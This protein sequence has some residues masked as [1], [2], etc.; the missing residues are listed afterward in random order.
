[1]RTTKRVV[2]LALLTF[3]ALAGMVFSGST[4]AVHSSDAAPATDQSIASA[5]SS[6]AGALPGV[7][8]LKANRESLPQQGTPRAG[9]Q[10]PS[11]TGNDATTSAGDGGARL[12]HAQAVR[13]IFANML[14]AGPVIEVAK[15]DTLVDGDGD[16]KIDPTNGIPATTEKITY[17]VTL[18]NTGDA[19]AT[20]VSF[21]DTIDPHTTLVPGS[22]GVTPVAVNDAYTA[23]G[24]VSISKDAAAGLLTNDFDP[25]TGSGSGFTAT[26]E[27]KK[28]ANCGACATNNVTINADGSFTYDPPPGFTGD[29]TF[30]YT[31]NSPAALSASGT[32]TI[33]ISGMIWFINNNAGA[34]GDATG[35]GRLSNPF[36]LISTFNAQNDGVGTHPKD[37]QNIFIYSSPNNYA[38]PLTLRNDQK[39]I[40][41]GS[42]AS[43]QTLTG[44]T[45][46]AGS[47]TL[48]STGGTP[49][50]ITTAGITLNS[51]N[52]GNLLRGFNISGTAG[53]GLAGSAFG[54]LSLT[55]V[56]VSSNGQALN[57]ANGTLSGPVASTAVFGTVSSGGGTDGI[58]LT[59]IAGTMTA[60]GGT[61]TGTASGPT[62]SVIGG[63]VNVTYNGGITQAANN[64]AVSVSGGHTTGTLLFQTGT[65]SAT[66]G[67]GLQ[68]SNADGVYQFTGTTTLNGGDAGID[69][70]TGSEGNFTFSTLTS[71]TNPTGDAFLVNGGGGTVTYN[72]TISKNSAGRAANIQSRTGGSV[73][74]TGSISSTG[75]SSGILVQNNSGGQVI[76]NNATKTLN[77]GANNA[78]TLTSNNGATINLTNGL[79]I[80]TTS[81][82]GFQATGG[83]IVNVNTGTNT[84]TSTSGQ[85]IDIDGVQIG[86][87]FN[88]VDST[89]STAQGIDLTNLVANSS[90]SVTGTTNVTNAGSSLG[91]VTT[92]SAGAASINLNTV[93]ASSTISFGATNINTRARTGIQMTSVQG[94]VGFGA[95]SI[96]LASGNTVPG[97]GIRVDTSSAVITIAS[98]S[99]SNANQ[100]IAETDANQDYVAES[101]GDGD[102]IF[103]KDNTNAAFRFNLNGGTLQDLDD[104]GVDVRNSGGVNLTGVTIQRPNRVNNSNKPG[105]HGFFA[106][107]L[108]GANNKI[109]TST[110]QEVPSGGGGIFVINMT[111]TGALLTLDDDTF[112]Q[113]AALATKTGDSFVI[114]QGGGT[115][116]NSL[117]IT[118]TCAFTNME[119]HAVQTVAGVSAGSTAIINTTIQNSTF[120]NAAPVTGFG[121]VLLNT[122][123]AGTNNILITG[124]TFDDLTRQQALAG[125]IGIT[126]AG[127]NL[128]GT[129]GGAG[130]LKNIIKNSGTGVGTG[131]RGI[132]IVS[133][134]PVGL[135]GSIDITVD[136]NDFDNL[137]DH[138]AIFAETRETT[139]A[140][141]LRIINNRIGQ[142]VGSIIGGTR[143]AIEVGSVGNTTSFKAE[144]SN[145]TVTATT[146]SR[147]V[148]INSYDNSDM[149]VTFVGNTLRNTNAAASP[150]FRA[151]TEDFNIS[152]SNPKLCLDLRNNTA[153]SGV[154]NGNGS[155]TLTEIAGTFTQNNSGN[156][157]APTIGAGVT[158]NG[159]S[160]PLPVG[161]LRGLP[162]DNNVNPNGNNLIQTMAVLQT[163]PT[164]TLTPLASRSLATVPQLSSVESTFEPVNLV[165]LLNASDNLNPAIAWVSLL[166]RSREQAGIINAT[167]SQPVTDRLRGE[168]N[169]A[170]AVNTAVEQTADAQT[171]A[172]QTL[173]STAETASQQTVNA[174][175]S[176][177]S[178][179]LNGADSSLSARGDSRRVSVAK[180]RR[181]A[182]LSHAVVRRTRPRA[183]LAAALAGETV[184]VNGSGSGFTLPPGKT[185]TITFQVTL[186]N[187]PNLTG[188]P[189]GPAQVSNQGKATGTNFADVLT[190]DPDPASAGG[191]SAATKDATLTPVDLF[192]TTTT[193]V[194]SKNPSDFNDAVT[195][196]ATVAS[197]PA[198][199]PTAVT[200]TVQFFDNGTPLTCDEGGANGVRP[201]SG[202]TAACTTSALTATTNP[203]P[204]HTI[205][206]Q[207]SGDGNY[208][209]GT[210]GTLAGGQTVTPCL[211]NPVVTSINDSGLNTLRAALAG[212]CAAPNNNVTFNLGAGAHTITTLSTLV[213]AKNV[214]ITNTIT[215]TNGALTIN[216]GGGNFN[217]FRVD[218]PVTTASLSGFTVTGVSATGTSGGG[219]LVQSG[220]VTLTGMLF[221]GNTVINGDGGAITAG[222]S[223]TVNL[224]NSTISGN[225][226]REGGGLASSGGTFN[227]LNVTITN[228]NA[229]GNTGTGACPAA[230]SINGSGGGIDTNNN[231][232][233]LTNTIISGNIACG[234]GQNA[235]GA[236]T[237]ENN[238]LFDGDQK[239]AALA[240]NGG[241]TRTHALLAGSPALDAGDNTAV[242]AIPLTTD[243]RGA[244]FGRKRDAADADTTQTVD[245]GAFEADPSVENITDKS[246]AEDTPLL[247][248][249]NVGDAATSFDS[250]T[251]TSSDTTLVPNLPANIAVGPD[252]ASSR[253]LTIT[254]ALNRTGTT[255]ITVTATKTI[256]G[257]AVSMSDTFVLTVDSINDP[258]SFTKGADPVVN[259]D[260]GAQTINGWATA[261]SQGPNETGQTL[262]FNVSV[263]GTTGTL[264]FTSAPAID[265]TTGNLTFTAAGD[266]NGT[267][268]VSVT[269]SDNGSNVLP[270]SN[271][272]APQT[273]TITVSPVNDPP[274]FTKGP[275]QN[276]NE[277]AGPQTVAGWA[278]AI[279]QGPNETGQTLTFN[280]SV[281]GTTGTLSFATAPAIDATTGTLTYEVTNGTSGTADVSVTLSD[282]GSNVL[283]NSN[284]S[285]PQTFTISVNGVN[286]APVNTVPGAISIPQ[287]TILTFTGANLIS[288]ADSDAAIAP[289]DGVITVTL[290]ATNGT[291]TLS[292]TAGLTFNPPG[293]NNDGTNDTSM[294][295]DG[296]LL[297]INAALNGMQFT[298]TSG[299]NGPASVQIVSN[300]QGKTGTGGAKSDT[301]SVAITVGPLATIYVNEIAFNPD[302]S[303]TSEYIELRGTPSSTI[304]AG[305]Y[306]VAIDGDS[307]NAGDVTT[308]INLSGLS[309]GTNGFLVLLQNGNTYTTASGA[310]VVTSTT[311]GFGGLPGGIFQADG[312]ATNLEN[313]SATFMLVQTGVVPTLS[314]DID[315]DNNGTSDGA[316]YAGWAVLDSI[317]NVDGGSS[318]HG[319]GALN[320]AT[321][322]S[323]ASSGTVVPVT[324]A[325][326]Y[327]GRRGDTT[328]S[329]AADWVASGA[330][331]GSAPNFTLDTLSTEVEPSSF[332][333][334]TLDH[335][336]STNFLNKTPVNTVPGAQV[337]DEDVPL[338]FTGGTKISISDSDAGT[339]SVK[340]TLTATGGTI[341]LSGTAGLTFTP[342]GANN[343]GTDDALMVFTGT[344]ANI[345]TALDGL[346][347]TPTLNY[348]GSAS[349]AILTDD[350]GNTGVDGAKT[351]S[352]TVLITVNAVNDPPSF[353]K[354]ADQT[355][356]EDAGAQTVNGWATSISQGAGDPAQTLTFNVSVASTTGNL[357][358]SSGPA[359]N[360]ATGDLTFTTSPDTN[361]TAEINV[362]LSDNGSNVS[363]NSN[364]SGVQKFTITVNAINDAPSFQIAS[365]P[366]AVNEDATAQTVN[367]FATNFLPGPATATDEAGQTLAGYAVTQTAT[368]GNLTFT[369][370]P[371]IDNSG[372]LTYTPT[373]N[374]SG[375]ATFNVVA[376][377][378][379]SGTSPNVNQS[380]PVPFTI[381][382]NGQNDA[383]VLD[384]NGNMSLNAISE[385]IADASNSG[386]LVSDIIASAG[387]DRIT[388]VDA[389]AIEGIAVTAVDN[390]NGAW[391]FS[392]NN[393]GSWTA[394]GTPNASSARLL[395]ADALTR[396]RF[397]P[398]LNFNGA[399]NPGLTF[400]A[401]D[402][403]SGANGNTADTSVVGGTTPFSTATET[404]SITVTEV[405]DAPTASNDALSSVGEDSGQRTIPFS[406]L[407]GNDST[408]PANESAQALIVK[409]VS[410][411]VGGAVSISG[412]NVLFT[413]TADYNG[414]ASF[415]YTVE[416]N[417]TTNGSAAPLTS[418]AATVSFTVTPTPD[419]PSVT[420]AT[421]NE[422]T[423][424]TTGLVITPNP[425]DGP[426]VLNFKITGITGGTL[427]QNDGTTQINNGDFI[428]V[429]QGAAGLK[430]TPAANS[431]SNGSFTVQAS[432]SAVDA[433]LG[434]GTA[435]ATIT[436]N[437]VNDAPTLNAIA[438]LTINED[439]PLQTVNLAGITAGG[440]ESQTLVVTATSNNTGLIPNPAVTYTSPN[441]TGSLSFTP[442]ADQSGSALITVTVSDGGGIA[443]G[444]VE[445]VVR[446]FTV[447]VN[448]V[449]DAPVNTVPGAQVTNADTALVFSSG[450]SNRFTISD[451]DAGAALVQVTLTA[452]NG[453]LTFA[454]TAGL[455]FT[456]GDGTADATMTFT[457][458]IAG[459]NGAFNVL[460]FTPTSGFAGTATVQITTNDQGNVGAGGPFSDTD[461][462]S[463]TVNQRSLQFS[464]LDYTVGEAEGHATIT[465]TRTGGTAEPA[466][467]AYETS[468]LAGLN[469]CDVNTGDASARCDYTAVGGTLTFAAGQSSKTFTVPV[470]NDVYVEGP[471]VLALTL[472]QPVGG[473]L[474]TPFVATLHITDN[475]P[476]PGAFNP[477]DSREFFI[478]QLY[479]DTL[480]REPE[481]SGL[482]AW[483]NRL[484]TCPQPGETIQNCDEVEVASAFFRSPEFFA[485]SYFIFKVY[486]VALGRQPQYAEY[487]RD[488]RRVTGFL[489]NEEL[490]ARKQQFVLEFTQRQE[491]RDRYDQIADS[492]QFV[493]TLLQTAGVQFEDSTRAALISQLANSHVQRWDVLRIVANSPEVSQK[494][495]NKAFVVVGYFAFL[496]RNPDAAYLH[497][498]E[499]LNTTG[500][501]REM[502]RVL[503]QSPEYRLRFGPM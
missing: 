169:A 309:F 425:G 7:A 88:S 23:T 209:A 207:Y 69:I 189:P 71:I 503:M 68:F 198:G 485:R 161:F 291:L 142:A 445:T 459:I 98:A 277:S 321:T 74:L 206:A 216:A 53:T 16:N 249:F 442:A 362:S 357:A 484:N 330:L 502:I 226:A 119:G 263:T 345:N 424:T 36:K 63:T 488:V 80:D 468:D 104:D 211:S 195:F 56:S 302:A 281:T 398:A 33:T 215:G 58:L 339:A 134:P 129:V 386:T 243:Q 123:Q 96:P 343:D 355:V 236:F 333:G 101:D 176:Q 300:D 11:G 115:T 313:D 185:V 1:M 225:T 367:S 111:Q 153:S 91:S 296:T 395:A 348:S 495:F 487:Q 282:N 2:L 34:P 344:L 188:V 90:F 358:F 419:T 331:G 164:D 299:Y 320:Y 156:T 46:P 64:A 183:A 444:G 181:T 148:D 301:D 42:S 110:I 498:I 149:S 116:N 147:V 151:V 126:G 464:S 392:I 55:E 217:A 109:Q 319:Y 285:A 54:T 429:A 486:E 29:D 370:G 265:A 316:I 192:D 175:V 22:I 244:G 354:G 173:A 383:P 393:G 245:I 397:V 159:G 496:R 13:R 365:N 312:G 210:A 246:T 341:S 15:A 452:T 266:T 490:E 407:T 304:P 342:A 401:W 443:N 385:D 337:A 233:N 60:S 430:F 40:G 21:T 41:G 422:D 117:T 218:S 49:P 165:A 70:T 379:G 122:A 387:G 204:P 223:S 474:G 141:E 24:N 145:N 8:A 322:G 408:G 458:T 201:I 380:A 391:Q 451:I 50:T 499:M 472:S 335:I 405:N 186:N 184:T 373:G 449:N 361:G 346:T 95:V 381:T 287:N 431:T 39:L 150:T 86:I 203:P 106:N 467:V 32:V 162:Q 247:L 349:L 294:T 396:I 85:A 278:T 27:T 436:V 83:G 454:S 253:T 52:T 112:T 473:V 140:S 227:L 264:T 315:S 252:T 323:G 61:L 43:I 501:Y 239:I 84:V 19:D 237:T 489:T 178:I 93:G 167:Y 191:A 20:G 235:S 325:L 446:T 477:I 295:F 338:T 199:N 57:L 212:I 155:F 409:A 289:G 102:A 400:R 482:A 267:A 99:I 369:S 461:S 260:A 283:P 254:P 231:I 87:T 353:T 44:I 412:G 457:G 404:A 469:N 205:T 327:V 72:G 6:E 187:P 194:S 363:P 171:T 28:S 31:T 79:D 38:G 318:D 416:D 131:R 214:N 414:P 356:N 275:D 105:H 447:T 240:D 168:I 433:G 279:S 170:V 493:D 427:F 462:V 75:T 250:I 166:N 82:I 30:T 130:A 259:E 121:G 466:S 270:N 360:A 35:D 297:A 262:T 428:T 375:T 258:P 135:T 4:V 139:G 328:G 324:F 420:N 332:A 390:A 251:A 326:T 257:T 152:P 232:T 136:N 238:N 103:L 108:R 144:I 359:I 280:V 81:G 406:A 154:G 371:S 410:N 242:D 438:D 146:T 114:M 317:G 9:A 241:L 439:A 132:H 273:F 306:L 268:D 377:D 480:N 372:V 340:V 284:T 202:G 100:S 276:I 471:E 481:P 118:N 133:E 25:Y 292:T 182:M 448:P 26:A 389:G 274:S 399:V 303:G 234:P 290:T 500:D 478:R 314:D 47:A 229:N 45:P 89:N 180:D 334:K 177:Q 59:T 382:V 368:T 172:A 293:A 384:N 66:G 230:G 491:F 453:T 460:T 143:R 12:N 378:S 222:S 364:T 347:F 179:A 450:N 14:V 200:G 120:Q 475:D 351:D 5:S 208:E 403:D 426:E 441:G 456:T 190:H 288:V 307:P 311:T 492:G 228:N 67:S 388:D 455:A 286:D 350:Q 124:S 483:L 435:T 157:P 138:Q 434:G 127:G 418:A 158:A 255:T 374:T 470:V 219:L 107:E 17:T 65:I 224:R 476:T 193:V 298:P 137:P 196:T 163:A 18:T 329:A 494:F 497:W 221:T 73:S 51:G 463:I 248:T 256:S 37:S 160:C 432:L 413:P 220:T 394:F 92:P 310:S 128:R 415:Q 437:P 336:G 213:I 366:P 272:S 48:P 78:V 94:T 174:P 423:Q 3:A 97:Y 197:N 77:T 261:I 113:P 271:T 376:T 417:G 305:T 411:A 62:F 125:M 479:L 269:L 440:G 465:V 76:F 308:I 352:D 10:A 421:T 402:Q